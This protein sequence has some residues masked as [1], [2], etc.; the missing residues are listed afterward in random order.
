RTA[1]S[2]N[3]YS[4]CE[5]RRNVCDRLLRT[6]QLPTPRKNMAIR[7]EGERNVETGGDRNHVGE[8][9]GGERDERRWRRCAPRY[10]RAVGARSNTK[11]RT[12]C[13]RSHSRESGRDRGFTAT[14]SPFQNRAF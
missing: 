2:R 3:R 7:L 5:I 6:S 12:I 10:D 1:A 8:R 4:I 9:N 13:D 11:G 14:G